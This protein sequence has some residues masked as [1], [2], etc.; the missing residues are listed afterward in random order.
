MFVCKIFN[1]SVTGLMIFRYCFLLMLYFNLLG[2]K[3][4]YS[5]EGILTAAPLPLPVPDS[6]FVKPLNFP[7]C[8]ACLNITD[9]DT[10]SW[11]FSYKNSVLCGPI[12][13]AVIT[14]ERNGFTFFGPSECSR[15]TGLIITVFLNGA[16]LNRDQ[17]NITTHNVSMEYYDNTS[18]IDILVGE[19][20][21]ISLTIT[22]YIDSTK[23]AKG[24][25]TGT[26][27]AGIQREEFNGGKF[28]IRFKL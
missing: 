11:R 16:V 3:K 4:D 18:G 22:Q 7:Q 27:L 28:L 24:F 2:C 13:N 6:S 26:A 20:N 12:T 5:F 19:R 14:P 23:T 25:F 15:D 8:R 10:P 21:S 17:I 1:K 9:Q